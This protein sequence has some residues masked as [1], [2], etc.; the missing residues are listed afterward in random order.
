MSS[1]EAEY[2]AIVKAAA[3]ALRIQA[4]AAD[5]GWSVEVQLLVGSNA[6]RSGVGRVRHLQVRYLWVQDAFSK[7]RL[8]M[9]KVA[10]KTNPAHVLTKPLCHQVVQ[11]LLSACSFSESLLE[12]N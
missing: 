11:D 1:G 10:G 2:Y 8:V 7:K 6:S 12:A 5:M 9:K 4:L 3:G